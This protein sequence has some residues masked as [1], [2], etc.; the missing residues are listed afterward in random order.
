MSQLNNF[1]AINRQIHRLYIF[2]L[3]SYFNWLKHG[4]HVC[5]G[6]CVCVCVCVCVRVRACVRACVRASVRVCVCV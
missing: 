4:A 5:R 3:I 2:R 1:V 6:V